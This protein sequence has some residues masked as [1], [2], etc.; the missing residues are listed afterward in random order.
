M[1]RLDPS[2]R[3]A[4]QDLGAGWWTT[5]RRVTLPLTPAGRGGGRADLPSRW[6]SAHSS[7]RRCSAAGACWC[8]RCRSTAPPRTSTGRSRRSAASRCSIARFVAVAAFNR[9]L[10]YSEVVMRARLRALPPAPPLR[11]VVLWRS[12]S[13]WSLFIIAPLAVVVLNSFSRSPTTSSRRRAIRCAGTQNLVGAGRVLRRRRG[14]AWSWRRCRRRSSLVI[15]MMAAYA[16]MRYRLPRQRPHQGAS[17][18]S[19][20]V[21]PKIV[22]GVAAVHVLRAHPHHGQLLEPAAGARAGRAC[23]SSS[24][25][26]RPRSPIS[27]GRSRRR[28]RISAPGLVTT[29]R[30]VILPQISV[31]VV[32]RRR[33]RLHHLVRPGRD[34]DLPGAARQQHAAGRD[35][36]L[37]AAL[38]GPDHRRALGRADRLR[39]SLLVALI[40]L[41]LRDRQIPLDPQRT[42]QAPMTQELTP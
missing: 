27:T 41:V 42:A 17:C 22:L 5:F 21:L 26:S 14:A 30:R 11:Y 33:V 1:T 7:R 32:R 38:A 25:W 3:E 24:R 16:L 6:R 37:S 29:F 4:A 31:S 2:L 20:M 35:V 13:W 9:L 36:P 39:R 28:R 23:P 12:P 40:S 18:M 8:C 15:G 34:H 19:P 10:K